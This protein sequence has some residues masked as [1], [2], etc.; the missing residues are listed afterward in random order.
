MISFCQEYQLLGR[1]MYLMTIKVTQ[2]FFPMCCGKYSIQ[3][4]CNIQAHNL[5]YFFLQ[6]AVIII[7]QHKKLIECICSF[8]FPRFCSEDEIRSSTSIPKNE[9]G[10]SQL[11]MVEG[12]IMG[13]HFL[14][15]N[16][17][18]WPARLQKSGQLVV[19]LSW[20]SRR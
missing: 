6:E 20:P 16:D 14:Q 11:P 15:A 17:H 18:H 1:E 5:Q 2:D 3:M 4:S 19:M 9:T 10:R 8:Y 7:I 13:Q 12:K